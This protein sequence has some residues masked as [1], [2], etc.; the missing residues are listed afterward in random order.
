MR[1]PARRPGRALL[2]GAAG[3]VLAALS[4]GCA[5]DSTTGDGT[6]TTTGASAPEG[7][8]PATTAV[9]LE[10]GEQIYVYLPEPGDCWEERRTDENAAGGAGQRIIL[11]LP[12][13]KPHE[14]E[15]F[16]VVEIPDEDFP[17]DGALQDLGKQECPQFFEAYVGTVY[18]LSVL[19]I[20]VWAPSQVDWNQTYSHS[21]ACYLYLPDD[22]KSEQTYRDTGL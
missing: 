20:G 2:V 7:T 1:R 21:L 12:C 6:S 22:A 8:A 19:E 17:G 14:R 15:T 11:R 10:E 3:A 4:V 13:D 16:G 5:G 18:E 9:P